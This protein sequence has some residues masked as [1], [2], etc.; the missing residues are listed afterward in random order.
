MDVWDVRAAPTSRASAAPRGR[1][2]TP[3]G[4]REG[5]SI[6]DPET[7]LAGPDAEHDFEV[8]VHALAFLEMNGSST[9]AIGGS[10][11]RVEIREITG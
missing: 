3:G 10:D 4:A 8:E 1:P 6:V 7:D 11:D 5:R 2:E 9:L